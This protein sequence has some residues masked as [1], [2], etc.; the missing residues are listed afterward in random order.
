MPIF[1]RCPH[2]GKHDW[3][4][5]H[6]CP[7]KWAIYR[8]DDPGGDPSIMFGA[9]AID[10]AEQYAAEHDAGDYD[11]MKG[12]ELIVIVVPY[13]TWLDLDFNTEAEA[14]AWLKQQPH[15]ECKGYMVPE[16]KATLQK[17]AAT[18]V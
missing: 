10:A 2:C 15:Y 12:E 18:P 17:T 11:M 4:D 14:T 8:A 5:K 16:Y 1:T 9:D 7:P 13:S 6:K 3:A